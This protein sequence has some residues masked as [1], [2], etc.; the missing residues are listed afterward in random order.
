MPASHQQREA[1]DVSTPQGDSQD[2]GV[3]G[4]IRFPDIDQPRASIIVTG[5][6]S[7]PH[8][9]GCLRTLAARVHGVPSEVIVSLN[10]PTPAVLG[11]LHEQVSG[12]RVLTS[13]VNR[14]FGQACN[15][16]VAAARGDLLVLLNDD[17]VVQDAW[18]ESLVTAADEH[19]QAG[20]VGSRIRLEDGSLQEEGAVIWAD[21]AITLIGYR[22]AVASPD[23]RPRRV[24]Y[25]SAASL[26][27]KRATWDA[28]GGIDA[29]YFPAYYEDV[30]LCLKIQAGG[31]SILYQP[32]STVIHRAG[33]STTESYRTFLAA[34]NRRRFAARWAPA[35]SRFEPP[36]P[37]SPEAV[38][39]AAKVGESRP[40]PLPGPVPH[41]DDATDPAAWTDADY[42]RRESEVLLAYAAVLENDVAAE[43][44]TARHLEARLV[45]QEKELERLHGDAAS[46]VTRVTELEGELIVHAH[47]G[48]YRLA[49]RAYEIASSIPGFQKALHWADARHRARVRP[50][51]PEP[52]PD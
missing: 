46:L 18:L 29:G 13:P 47:R 12:L 35:L 43:A 24:D 2:Q 26:L 28:A 42:L 50:T 8:L 5:W 32:A 49:D 4:T 48:R 36:E 37:G 30:D 7:A 40:L 44:A 1:S 11:A 22:D 51:P 19:P 34:R 3:A 6:R 45:Q 14:G 41:R 27:V 17:A 39:R 23:L 33:S 16:G 38:A 21:G 9:I 31:Q 10:E 15:L 25:C 20:A 52:P